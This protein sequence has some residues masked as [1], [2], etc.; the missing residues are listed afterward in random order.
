MK[1]AT[2][3]IKFDEEKLNAIKQYMGKKDADLQTEL[4]DVMQKLYE[5]HVPAPVREYIE[6]RD[7]RV[8]EKPKRYA[9]ISYLQPACKDWNEDYN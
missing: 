3:Q 9:C 4:D 7:S 8:Q 1:Q 5:K 2:L 6:S